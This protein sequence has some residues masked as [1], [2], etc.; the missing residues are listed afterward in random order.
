MSGFSQ[1][2]VNFEGFQFLLIVKSA[3]RLTRL[4]FVGGSGVIAFELKR[5][6]PEMD[7]SVFE[8]E[9]IVQLAKEKFVPGKEHLGVKFV[10]GEITH[11]IFSAEMQKQTSE[12]EPSIIVNIQVTWGIYILL[13][14]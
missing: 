5:Q 12:E 10:P 1:L 2:I 14:K 9:N 8:M 3:K 11:E 4:L 6:Y 13:L 7:V